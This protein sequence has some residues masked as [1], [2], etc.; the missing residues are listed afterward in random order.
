[1]GNSSLGR[2][3]ASGSLDGLAAITTRGSSSRRSD[4][5]TARCT[6]RTAAATRV[7]GSKA[8]NTGSVAWFSQT[9]HLSKA[10]LTTMRS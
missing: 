9:N 2:R 8:F 7:I 10:N 3:V 1:M 4:M 6:G 5:A